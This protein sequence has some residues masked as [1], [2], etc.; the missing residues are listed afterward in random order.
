MLEAAGRGRLPEETGGSAWRTAFE[1]LWKAAITRQE[2]QAAASPLEAHW[3]SAVT[4]PNYAKKKVSTRRLCER[5]SSNRPASHDQERGS[6]PSGLREQRQSA[7][8]G[9]L[10]GKA[11]VIIRAPEPVIEDYKTG[12]LF[13]ADDQREVKPHY[14][15]Q[16]LLYA[17]LEHEETGVWPLRAYLIPLEG[18]RVEIKIDPAEA[19]QAAVRALE[20]LAHYNRS[21]KAGGDPVA[22]ASPTPETCLFCPYAIECPAFWTTSNPSWAAS[23]IVAASGE[24]SGSETA[25]NGMLSLAI[26]VVRGSVAPGNYHLY[27]LDPQ[28]FAVLASA[29]NGTEAAATWLRGD[30]ASSQLRPTALTQAAT[31]PPPHEPPGS[32]H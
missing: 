21:V 26:R 17:V 14:R 25:Q 15:L 5:I 30:P 2:E 8:D 6:T 18:Q 11:D 7:F 12:A 16:M 28:R 9:R 31:A 19:T 23:E 3:G 24:V 13:E 22:L 1:E 10:I 29:P 4:W 27:D 32:P 20:D